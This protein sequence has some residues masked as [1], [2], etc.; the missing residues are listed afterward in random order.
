[1]NALL[2]QWAKWKQLARG[3]G[4]SSLLVAHPLPF[5]FLAQA[6]EGLVEHPEIGGWFDLSF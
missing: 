3:V 5:I 2:A 6:L 1:M 4:G